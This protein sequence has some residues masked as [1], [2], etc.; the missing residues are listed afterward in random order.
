MRVFKCALELALRNPL[1]LLIYTVAL[2]F[3]GVAMALGLS[4]GQD[5]SESSQPQRASVEY[6][7]IDRDG[8]TLAQGMGSFLKTCGDEVT[9]ED[10]PLALQDAVAKGEADFILIIPEG[11][12]DAFIRAA[13]NGEELPSMECVY[14][15]Y[16]A[17]G[18]LADAR[19]AGFAGILAASIAADPEASQQQWVHSALDAVATEA[20]VSFAAG[21]KAGPARGFEFFLEF[22][23]YSLFAS[24][25]VCVSMLLGT[26]DR[27]D[28]RRRHLAS[29][30][31]YGSYNAQTILACFVIMLFI[32]AWTLGLGLAVF[33]GSAAASGI[34]T[35]IRMV[36]TVPV[37]SLVPLGVG[38]LL[39]QFGIGSTA[40]NGVGNIT[41]LVLSFLGG[42][43]MPLSMAPEGVQVVAR[44]LPGYWYIEALGADSWQS[45]LA[46]WGV[47][48]LFAAALF[49]TS[50]VA[51]KLRT[52]TSEAGGNAAAE[53]VI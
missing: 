42:A 46:C 17:E 29:P 7:V 36:L 9:L 4:D 50:L 18:S 25:V 10:T 35:L 12:G 16:S 30:V 34:D 31:S 41:A 3:M 52:R 49:A 23:I 19:L 20:S 53:V 5:A 48:L 24:I 33:H 44:F 51:A 8:G 39:G 27:A 38:Y 2:S 37:F 45:M 32:D 14:S 47:L 15:F 11:W 22:S 21:E 43:W 1:P 6:A 28:V 40:A 13:E 26:L